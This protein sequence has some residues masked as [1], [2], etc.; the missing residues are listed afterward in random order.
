MEGGDTWNLMV[1]LVFALGDLGYGGVISTAT[2]KKEG[3][4]G[5]GYNGWCVAGRHLPSTQANMMPLSLRYS[6]RM[7]FIWW[8]V[9]SPGSNSRC[10]I[11]C[12]SSW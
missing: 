2:D 1:I 6:L 9:Y 4:I 5:H 7:A 10:A 12:A 11:S 8:L 3:V